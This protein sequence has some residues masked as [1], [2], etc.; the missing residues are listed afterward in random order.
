M[1][2]PVSP[3]L[4]AARAAVQRLGASKIREVAN[5]GMGLA[6]V[7]PFWFG[8]SDRPTPALIA[9]AARDALA[10][11]AVFYTPNLGK[12]ALRAELAHY[13]SGLHGATRVEHI[14]V[15]SAGVNALML[16]A[17]LLLD[18]G[19]EVVALTPL[20]P[21]LLEIPR[22]LGAQ[23]RTVSLDHVAGRWQLD[24]QRLIDAIGPRT[25][26]LMLNSP[27]NP[28]GWVMDRAA[29]QAVLA[30]CRRLGVWIL[31]DEVYERLYYA[32]APCAPTFLD[33]AARDERVISVN[34]FSKAWLMTGWRLGWI[35]APAAM[36]DD[37]GKL[38][39][40]NTSCAPDFVQQAGCVAVR[41][42]EAIVAEVRAELRAR[43][44]H[45]AAALAALPGL[46]VAPADGAMYLFFKLPG[47]EDS[48]ALCKR[49]VN[50][51]G[52][53]LA[54][55]AAFGA[56]GEGHVRWCYAREQAVLDEG[57]ARLARF[58]TPS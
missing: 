8:E 28:T 29:Q 55:G 16:C 46:E 4:P 40:F 2:V 31:A 6:D 54:P 47:A 19:D 56:D 27:N 17:Q 12:P 7:L 11:G 50:E 39:E 18:P 37:L 13:V 25:R 36:L 15:T 41:H 23:V 43:R 9:D 20:W 24:V 38:I 30:H 22:I 26:V 53:G 45:L 51:A 33:I 5:A 21:N 49:L 1:P 35:T 48:V 34:S 58:L 44:D 3:H 32:D 52:L 57:V 14:G 10:S 42:G